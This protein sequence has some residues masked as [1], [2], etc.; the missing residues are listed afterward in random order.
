MFTELLLSSPERRPTRTRWTLVISF[1]AEATVLAIVLLFPLIRMQALPTL[2]MPNAVIYITAQAPPPVPLKPATVP[3]IIHKPA[4]AIP[5][6]MPRAIPHGIASTP[7][8]APDLGPAGPVV[9]GAIPAVPSTGWTSVAPNPLPAPPEPA[10]PARVRVGGKVRPPRLIHLVRVTYPPIAR[11][12][13]VQGDVVLHAVIATDGTIENLEYVSGPALLVRA[14]MDAVRLWRY[15][16]TLLN[17]QP[18]EVEIT[19]V[20]SFTLNGPAGR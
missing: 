3:G 4:V 8:P 10:R 17:G 2:W 19:V 6:T 12:A 20:V 18:V 11:Q 16:P 7:A 5:F 15:E 14:A 1:A 13:G 9:P